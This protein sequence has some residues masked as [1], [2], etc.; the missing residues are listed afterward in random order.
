MD[1]QVKSQF[2]SRYSFQY[3]RPSTISADGPSSVH[4]EDKTPSSLTLDQSLDQYLI[5]KLDKKP[6]SIRSLNDYAVSKLPEDL[7]LKLP[8]Q[9]KEYI[10]EKF[11]IIYHWKP[12]FIS[13]F[14][15]KFEEEKL[16]V[17]KNYLITRNLL[18]QLTTAQIN[19][20]GKMKAELFNNQDYVEQWFN[21]NYSERITKHVQGCE[22]FTKQEH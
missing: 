11:S 2:A 3:P 20:L 10:L 7:L 16:K 15:I 17:N 13:K 14:I 1:R 21:L 4:Q 12:E 6:S 5:K 9:E 19:H 8:V 22:Y 18:A